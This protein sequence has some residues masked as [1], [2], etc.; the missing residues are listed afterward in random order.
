MAKIDKLG[1]LVIPKEYRKKLGI[2]CGDEIDISAK[3]GELII[4]P[5]ALSCRICGIKLAENTRLPVY[6]SCIKSIRFNSE[7][8]T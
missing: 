4:K 1:R 6:N 2:D 7:K 3:D 5:L 8:H